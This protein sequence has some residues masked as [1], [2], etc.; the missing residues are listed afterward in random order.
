MGVDNGND[1]GNFNLS[2]V[3][4]LYYVFSDMTICCTIKRLCLKICRSELQIMGYVNYY[5]L[6][7]QILE[8]MFLPVVHDKFI[9]EIGFCQQRIKPVVVC[10]LE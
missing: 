7:S 5:L 3:N 8:K 2:T 1:N 6:Q 10:Y 4:L 9:W